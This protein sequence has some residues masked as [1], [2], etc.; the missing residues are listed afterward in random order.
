MRWFAEM[1]KLALPKTT[2]EIAGDVFWISAIIGL[3]VAGKIG[4]LP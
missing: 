4:L 2:A 1:L 3:A